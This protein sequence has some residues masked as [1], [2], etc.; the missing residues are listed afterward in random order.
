MLEL[1]LSMWTD[2]TA[3]GTFERWATTRSGYLVFT[4]SGQKYLSLMDFANESPPKSG[5]QVEFEVKDIP[6]GW[7]VPYIKINLPN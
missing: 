5:E 3:T 4:I 1:L 6:D 2:M 7:T